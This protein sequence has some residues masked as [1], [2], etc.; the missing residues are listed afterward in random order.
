MSF[1]PV[2]LPVEDLLLFQCR[3]RHRVQRNV[4][5]VSPLD[6]ARG[7]CLD[8]NNLH[9][10]E[11]HLPADDAELLRPTHGAVGGYDETWGLLRMIP[12]SDL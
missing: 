5:C 3:G 12:A 10:L 6:L 11:V 2:C 8:P 7:L 4:S 1:G 9:S